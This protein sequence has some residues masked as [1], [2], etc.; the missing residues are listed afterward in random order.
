[1]DKL[2]DAWQYVRKKIDRYMDKN[3][4]KSADSAD[5]IGS[6]SMKVVSSICCNKE[7]ILI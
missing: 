1:M 3:R 4:D 5:E 7:L 2:S 6:H